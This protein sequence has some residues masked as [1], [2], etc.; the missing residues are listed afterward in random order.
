MPVVTHDA[1]RKQFN[2]ARMPSKRLGQHPLESQEIPIGPEHAIPGIGPIQDVIT[3]SADINAR[4]SGHGEGIPDKPILVK[5]GMTCP[6][7]TLPI[8]PTH[9]T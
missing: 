8:E 9:G 2:P 6:V 7:E 5:R 3:I 4:G 1:V